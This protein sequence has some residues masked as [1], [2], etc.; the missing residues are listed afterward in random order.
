MEEASWKDQIMKKDASYL[1]KVFKPNE[2]EN[3]DDSSMNENQN[4]SLS[5]VNSD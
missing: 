2:F 4:A 1:N 5:V 3:I